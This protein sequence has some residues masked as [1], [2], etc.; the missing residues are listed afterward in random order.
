MARTST[1]FKE[2]QGG[3][4]KNSKNKK[5]LILNTFAQSIVEGG[6][7]K[8]KEE[9]DKL[10]GKEYIHAFMTLFEYVKPKLARTEMTGK[11]GEPIETC[12]ATDKLVEGMTPEQLLAFKYE[13]RY[14][15]LKNK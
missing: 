5:T 7:D 12:S 1:T 13:H 4:K 14:N 11:D 9:L 8:F 3:R 10:T 15:E 6:M 2:G